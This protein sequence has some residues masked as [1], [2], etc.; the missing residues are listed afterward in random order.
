MAASSRSRL[1]PPRRPAGCC[2]SAPTCDRLRAPARPPLAHLISDPEMSHSLPPRGGRHHFFEV[3][4]FSMALSSIAS[5]SK[6]LQLGVLVLQRLQPPGVRH[7][8]AAELGLPLVECRAADP[9]LAAH[10]RRLRPGLL[11]PQNPD[12]LLFREPARFIVRPLPGAGLYPFLEEVQGLRS[13]IPSTLH[14]T[15]TSASWLNA[16]EGF[17]AKVRSGD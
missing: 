4:S 1:A 17:F 5:A 14:F 10:V 2:D 6:L 13:S 11:L 15:P 8:H 9:V 16:V 12:D 3:R 7:V